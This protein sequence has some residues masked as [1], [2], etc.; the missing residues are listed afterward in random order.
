M[1][2]SS[3]PPGGGM[4]PPPVARSLFENCP[5]PTGAK[6]GADEAKRRGPM[7]VLY[8]PLL[9]NERRHAGA[10]PDP[11]L[12]RPAIPW[13]S[14]DRARHHTSPTHVTSL[15]LSTMRTVSASLVLCLNIGV[16][17]P[18]I[19]KPRPCAK[20]ECWIDPTKQPAQKA[21]E[22]I[23]KALQAQY[24]RWQS[25]A[26]YKQCLDPTVDDVRRLCTSHRRG[27]K[28]DRQLFHYNGHGVPQPTH[29]GEI[30]V[31]N[32][33][34]TQ[35]IPLSIYELQGWVGNPSLYVFDCN[36][37]GLIVNWFVR[38]M[39]QRPKDDPAVAAAPQASQD[40]I[41]LAACGEN[42]LLPMNPD[43]PADIFT[44][45][46]TTPIRI[47]LLWFC[48]H[49]RLHKISPDMIDRLPGLPNNRRTPLGE[50]NWIFTTITDT[51]AWNILPREL[52][53]KLFRQD[54]LVASL[55]RN[56]L[57]AERIMRSLNCV[58]VSVPRLPPAFKHP[59]WEAW[60]LAVDMCL[61]QMP[62]LL[63]DPSAEYY[64]SS[65]FSEQL[66][67][68]EVWLEFGSEDKSPPEQ[69]PI[70]L[71]VLLSQSYRH[72]ALL[73]LARFLDMGPWAAA[74]SLSVGIFPYVLKLLVSPAPEL[75]EVLV[76]IWTKLLIHDTDKACQQD[77]LRENGHNYFISVLGTSLPSAELRYMSAF[78]LSVLVD[79]C[80]PAQEACLAAGLLPVC[81]KL[82]AEP[83]AMLRKWAVLCLGKLWEGMGDAKWAAIQMGVVDER[84]FKLLLDDAPEVRAAA[85]F[86]LGTF[87]GPPYGSG[88]AVEARGNVE[89][90]IGLRLFVS[91][92]DASPVVRRELVVALSRLVAAHHQAFQD[93]AADMLDEEQREAAAASSASL[94]VSVRSSVDLR[95]SAGNV[96]RGEQD[97][98][99][100]S[101]SVPA[102]TAAGPDH[103]PAMQSPPSSMPPQPVAPPP[104]PPQL[105]STSP[106]KGPQGT[107]G[108][109]LVVQPPPQQQ[110]QQQQ[111]RA[112]QP[113]TSSASGT[114]SPTSVYAWLW[115]NLM[116]MTTDPWSEVMVRSERIVQAVLRQ[117]DASSSSASYAS[118]GSLSAG[119]SR[120]SLNPGARRSAVLSGLSGRRRGG[121]PTAPPAPLLGGAEAAPAPSLGQ[122]QGPAEE[123]ALRSDYFEWSCEYF[124]GPLLNR[125]AEDRTSPEYKAKEQR[126]QQNMGVIR[127]AR[128]T[129]SQ[130][131]SSA[132]RRKL[133]TEVSVMTDGDFVLSML[134]FHPFRDILAVADE[135]DGLSVWDWVSAKKLSFFSNLNPLQSRITAL[136]FANEQDN[137]L[138]VVGSNDGVVR[139]WKEFSSPDSSVRRLVTSWKALPDLIPRGIEGSGLLMDWLDAGML[140][141]TGDVSVVRLWD[142]AAEQSAVEIPTNCDR[143]VTAISSDRGGN[144]SGRLF[145]IGCGDGSVRLFDVRAPPRT[146]CIAST[147]EH[148]RYILNVAMSPL[149]E[150]RT[151]IISGSSSGEIRF[152]DVASPHSHATVVHESMTALAVHQHAPIIASGSAAQRI[153]IHGIN[154]DECNTIKYH[155]GF[156]GQR[157]G[158]VSCLAFH[159]Y[160]PLLAAGCTDSWVSVYSDGPLKHN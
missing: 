96:R 23:G 69:L 104:I 111:A 146:A 50:L 155:E 129:C 154:G 58:P 108:G 36:C 73:L 81:A 74:Q 32:K 119:G 113:A 101:T 151:V 118:S 49:S 20:L 6:K 158:P 130:W 46:L 45:C 148:R 65:F 88:A 5:A 90:N 68:F 64:P 141:T 82:L 135:K 2:T 114:P 116:T 66:T 41:L 63:Q 25:K 13:K 157:I 4:T 94:P 152:W 43:Y 61:A 136:S 12:R 67:A 95:R 28:D 70:V 125:L 40:Y 53:Q 109:Q 55:F 8:Q 150:A 86:A 48:K 9:F 103:S 62:R 21:L 110:Q 99:P 145:A 142:L 83:D 132:E 134:L 117:V 38:F 60:D 51:I 39:E 7:A 56:F 127:E 126:L 85:V 24:E 124:Y 29:N 37:A 84:L 1:P 42:E 47:A 34:Y 19:I 27:Y 105:L 44:S 59:L 100:V 31:F 106:S 10:S 75:R 131:R 143:S 102:V 91:M 139:A 18:D 78:I 71:Q 93:A 17:P 54:L 16:D 77:L 149:S 3:P 22:Q 33:N 87:I 160:R 11:A 144:G 122:Q 123:I 115:K 14:K 80:R 92:Q 153:K 30:W 97:T 159:P 120:R 140:L 72:R 79:G 57:L 156:L 133:S 76:F 128:E 35:Y 107:Q 138:L 89:L 98:G 15:H 121:D 137:S 26:R 147:Q 52:F 112:A